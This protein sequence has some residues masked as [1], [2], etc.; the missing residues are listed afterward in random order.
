MN[1]LYAFLHDLS[2]QQASSLERH[3]KKRACLGQAL[4]EETE[5]RF[6]SVLAKR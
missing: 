5:T 4:F 1:C 3:Q 2:L 6:L